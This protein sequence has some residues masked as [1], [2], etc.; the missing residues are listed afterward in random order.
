MDY[1]GKI[2]AKGEALPKGG[3]ESITF[4][5]VSF[6]LLP[7]PPPLLNSE[8]RR[9]F[10][11]VQAF[12]PKAKYIVEDTGRHRAGLEKGQSRARH[13]W[14]AAPEAWEMQDG[15]EEQNEGAPGRKQQEA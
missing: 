1:Y 5:L 3:S 6:L 15:S 7:P 12:A 11:L 8:H 10:K 13:S 2:I 14:L 9:D 4:F